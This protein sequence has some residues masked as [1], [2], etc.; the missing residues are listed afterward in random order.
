MHVHMHMHMHTHL[1]GQQRPARHPRRQVR[2]RTVVDVNSADTLI[3]VLFE[4]QPTEKKVRARA[5]GAPQALL[6]RYVV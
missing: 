3:T 6:V 2:G 5:R 1:F 4:P